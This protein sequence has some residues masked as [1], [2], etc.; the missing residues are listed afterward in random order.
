[1]NT[2]KSGE[3]E[4]ETIEIEGTNYIIIK[5]HIVRGST[6]YHLINEDD[7]LDSMYR[8]LSSEDDDEEYLVSLGSER[9]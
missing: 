9:E 1:M 5:E 4:M 7:P 6:Y 2:D 8:K 3:I